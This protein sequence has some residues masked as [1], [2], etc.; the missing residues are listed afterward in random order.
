MNHSTHNIHPAPELLLAENQRLRADLELLHS[1][2]LLQQSLTQ[3]T[4]PAQIHETLA[5][6]APGPL[7]AQLALVCQQSDSGHW[8]AVA[9]P[10]G[11]DINQRADAVRKIL[12]R[13]AQHFQATPN[14]HPA[15]HPAA[16]PA[17]PPDTLILPLQTATPQTTAPQS[18]ARPTTT[19]LYLESATPWTPRRSEL[20]STLARHAT[21]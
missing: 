13:V 15:P 18:T 12:H 20:A 19:A 11:T 16:T 21:H 5:Q 3:A 8:T 6:D 17:P 4:T 14:T 9:G 1:L 7:Q 10:A 2:Q